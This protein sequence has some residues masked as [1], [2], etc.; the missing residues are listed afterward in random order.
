VRGFRGETL[1]S[2]SK[3]ICGD[4]GELSYEGFT[5]VFRPL[6]ARNP[7]TNPLNEWVSSDQS[8]RYPKVMLH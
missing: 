6:K 5:Q 2:S 1:Y 3:R 7:Q 4:R 8:E